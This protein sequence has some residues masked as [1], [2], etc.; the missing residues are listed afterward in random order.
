MEVC[1]R[2]CGGRGESA[3]EMVMDKV[4]ETGEKKSALAETPST[5]ALSRAA[6]CYKHTRGGGLHAR[7]SQPPGNTARGV[8]ARAAEP[9]LSLAFERVRVV[10]RARTRARPPHPHSTHAVRTYPR[11]R[12][13]LSLPLH[14]TGQPGPSH[15]A[16]DPV[17]LQCWQG[18]A[19]DA[20]QTG[21]LLH[22]P[23]SEQKISPPT[24]MAP[25]PRHQVQAW[26][27]APPQQSQVEG[28]RF[29]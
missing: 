16:R 21:Q 1:P 19:P 29:F 5:R 25:V 6:C 3:Q 17:P 11:P 24:I 26:E 12:L 28:A 8:R 13:S 20:L 10:G 27:P 7:M 2:A 22:P 9:V 4:G 18:T 14:S 15:A 23:A